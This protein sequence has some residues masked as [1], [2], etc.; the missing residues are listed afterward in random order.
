M[1]QCTN[2]VRSNPTA[3]D[4]PCGGRPS[5]LSEL[6]PLGA[7]QINS[8]LSSIAQGHAQYLTTQPT[9]T[10]FG[11]DGLRVAGRAENAGYSYRCVPL[12]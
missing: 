5:W 9:V 4:Y 10:H 12:Q 3:F 8:V 11:P 2:A 7:L 6:S 1:V